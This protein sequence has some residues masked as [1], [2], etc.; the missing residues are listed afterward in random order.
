MQALTTSVG[1]IDE[2]AEDSA[3][4]SK[5]KSQAAKLPAVVGYASAIVAS[6]A[7]GPCDV[8]G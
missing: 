8:V 4:G 5:V 7:V 6:P 2:Y 1:G 3:M